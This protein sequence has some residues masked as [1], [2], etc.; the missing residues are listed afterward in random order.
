MT[1][2][3]RIRAGAE[4]PAQRDATAMLEVL[5][6][7]RERVLSGQVVAFAVTAID[8]N[9]TCYGYAGSD[10]AASVSRLRMQG[11][12]SQLLHD[13]LAGELDE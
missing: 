6:A 11:A 3:H 2:I 8:A 5:D 7:L 13:Y 10:K 12:I 4:V 1:T 9:D